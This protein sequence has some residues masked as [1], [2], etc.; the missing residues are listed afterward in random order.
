MI[1]IIYENNKVVVIM[2]VMAINCIQQAK[3]FRQITIGM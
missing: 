3:Y 1:E 2:K